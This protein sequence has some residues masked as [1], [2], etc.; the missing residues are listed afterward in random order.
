M[1]CTEV[2]LQSGCAA[3]FEEPAAWVGRNSSVRGL[4]L[5]GQSSQAV[6]ELFVIRSVAT[7]E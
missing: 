1:G 5:L 2:W 3:A 7:G 4:T 6:G